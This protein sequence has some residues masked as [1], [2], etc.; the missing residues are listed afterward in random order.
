MT[1]KKNHL[2]GQKSPYLIQ[3]VYNPV[4]WHPWSE[5]TFAKAKRDDKP[6]FLSIGYSTCHW[7]HVMEKESFEDATVAKAMNDAFVSIKV[8]REER[9]DIDQFYMSVC[10]MMT[11]SGGWPLNLVLDS[12]KRPFFA[13]TYIPKESRGGQVGLIDLTS[14]ISELWKEKRS[15]LKDQADKV[16]NAV[17]NMGRI[18]KGEFDIDPAWE[19]T[20]SE[21]KKI[22]DPENGGFGFRPKFPNFPYLNFLMRY[23]YVSREKEA[24]DMV[25]MTLRKI[26]YGGVYDQIGFGLHRY[27]TDP[28]WTV[29]HFEKMLYDQA[30]A[31][32][33]Y[34]EAYQIT[35]DRFFSKVIAEIHSFLTREMKDLGGGFYSAM[36]ADSGA[37][38][39]RY[40]LWSYAELISILG[41]DAEL[42]SE[43]YNCSSKGNF[44]D[45]V[46][47]RSNHLNIL[48]SGKPFSEYSTILSIDQESVEKRMNDS[49]LKLLSARKNREAPGI[50]K[51]V[52]T[53]LNSL[54][55]ISLAKA[56][57]A[58]G[59]EE[60]LRTAVETV[61]FI[62]KNLVKENGELLHE[63][64]KGST[65]GDGMLNDYAYLVSAL[66]ELYSVAPE[67]RYLDI[68]SKVNAK[69]L[70]V[71]IDKE[72]GFYTSPLKDDIPVRVKEAYDA[73]LPS[74]NSIELQN[75]VILSYLKEKPEYLE[76]AQK[77]INFFAG[78]ASESP[79]YFAVLIQSAYSLLKH[80]YFIKSSGVD[81]EAYR[82]N[83]TTGIEFSPLA[84]MYLD[85]TQSPKVEYSLCTLKE[86]RKPVDSLSK[87]LSS[88]SLEVSEK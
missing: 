68:A 40:Y 88:I 2:D 35:G 65:F 5:E 58:T 14:Q 64:I 22:Y 85:S 17:K 43:I 60:Y 62:L 71:F 36:D 54:L 61:D 21:L 27:S 23:H 15:E 80:A 37:G 4:D 87:V 6:V 57:K 73:P 69:L 45:E 51:K 84:Y 81:N 20:Y 67:E 26:R 55:I 39:G 72:G 42:F 31:I 24:L 25:T 29:P 83:Y 16:V 75:L 7:C 34:A 63:M 10:Q 48:Y 49:R 11:G 79:Q 3:H 47:G 77:E 46:T 78:V 8:D 56:Y 1:I 74:G 38:E 33:S 59:Q 70:D 76:I 44:V 86:C 53:E 28:Q 19:K 13:F 9:P 32:W 18:R 30:M 12:D 52:V 82:K 41:Q 50:D 66:L